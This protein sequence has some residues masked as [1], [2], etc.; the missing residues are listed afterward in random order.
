MSVTY[1]CLIMARNAS[2]KLTGDLPYNQR[3]ESYI[4]EDE[5]GHNPWRMLWMS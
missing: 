5:Q 2:R 3:A 4:A 1:F